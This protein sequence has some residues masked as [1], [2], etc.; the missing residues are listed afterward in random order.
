[1]HCNFDAIFLPKVLREL[2]GKIY[3]AVLTAGAS[4]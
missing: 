3:R 4:E 1:M 2:L